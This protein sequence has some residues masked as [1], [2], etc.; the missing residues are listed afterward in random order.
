MPYARTPTRRPA[1][2]AAVAATILVTG[3][4]LATTAPP[5]PSGPAVAPVA[6]R[7]D[8][9]HD[10]PDG[11]RIACADPDQCR[12]W[13]V[14]W[15]GATAALDPI[16][17]QVPDASAVTVVA[18]VP[19]GQVAVVGA[20][21]P[22]PA[23]TTLRVDDT[24]VRRGVATPG[25]LDRF[26]IVVNPAIAAEP[27][28]VATEVL[29]HELVHVRTRAADLDGPLWVEEGYAVALAHRAL[30]PAAGPAATTV[31]PWPDDDWVPRT[32]AEYGAAG[33]VVEDLATR[34]GWDG[35]DR[36]Y[37]ATSAGEPSRTAAAA[38]AS[39]LG[40]ETGPDP[41]MGPASADSATGV[42]RDH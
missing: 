24:L 36:W 38:L 21:D 29:T 7:L 11:T 13:Q 41:R 20:Q 37:A 12:Y 1:H 17:P 18:P 3:I 4:L 26:W 27:E 28:D 22:L 30:G 8:T 15:E 6:L 2:R 5:T 10:L 31:G 25:Q 34:I 42:G 40:P 23:A 19:A 32:L 16:L 9:V 33:A 35:V 39:S 14:A